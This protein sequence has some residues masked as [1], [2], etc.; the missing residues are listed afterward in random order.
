MKPSPRS[1]RARGTARSSGG[2]RRLPAS[3]QQV[4]GGEL[5]QVDPAVEDQDGLEAAVGQEQ[6]VSWQVLG[7]WS[8]SLQTRFSRI[9]S[10]R[11]IAVSH[12]SGH[13][14]LTPVKRRSRQPARSSW[15]GA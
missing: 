4:E 6:V 13:S 3:L 1:R 11:K 5:R 8:W 2:S 7:L 14:S 9:Y 12:A 15:A 10:E